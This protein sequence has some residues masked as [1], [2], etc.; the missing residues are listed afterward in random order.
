M[1]AYSTSHSTIS[2]VEDARAFA[3]LEQEWSDLYHDSPLVTPFQS[4]AWLYSW[5]QSYGKR[6]ELRLIMVRNGEGLLVGI[7]PLMLERRRGFRRLL[8][9]GTGASDYLDVLARKG[10]EAEVAEAGARALGQIGA[11][12]VADLH[13]LRPASA[14]WGI[15]ERWDGPKV[16]V[17]QDSCPM[18]DV[19]P[20]DEL[21]GSLSKNLRKTVRRAISRV[22]ADGVRRRVAQPSDAERAARR[23]VALHRETWQGRVISP[24]HL[25]KR[26]ESHIVAAA[27]RMTALGLGGISEFWRDGEVVISYLWVSEE[28][29]FATYIAGASQK[30]LQEYQ[31]SSLY[32]WDA[33]LNALDR[34]CS[35][36]D[37]LRGEEPY[38]LRWA[39]KVVATHRA[40]LGRSRGP[41]RPYAAYY[42]LRSRAKRYVNSDEVPS[43]VTAALV[44]SR[45]LRRKVM[46]YANEEHRPRWINAAINRLMER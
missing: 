18:I 8:F 30:A 6:Y 28:D 34:S 36:V 43:W 39:S 27:R 32:I 40:I 4:W 11:W 16:R 15:F 44:R 25:T 22:E 17:W 45:V 10:W 9:V 12:Q 42:V 23:L 7:F 21:T 38:K 2:I 5:W 14:A 1:T 41:W 26:F 33:V 29:F 31:W 46:R 19:K 20:W 35:T 24:G 13:Q 37:L 3:T